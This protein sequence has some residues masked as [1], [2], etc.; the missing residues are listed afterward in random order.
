MNKTEL[1]NLFNGLNYYV[2][3]KSVLN[4]NQF[5]FKSKTITL[6]EEQ[7][8][9]VKSEPAQHQ[10]ILAGAG[11]GKTTTILCRIKYLLD[12]WMCPDRIL[13]L[14]FNRDSAQSI[15]NRLTDLFGF[16]INFLRVIGNK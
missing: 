12:Y 11:S 2:S 7:N 15:R 10:R 16:N 4:S 5:K 1:K 3:N 6:S 9:I 8:L 13:I 14:T